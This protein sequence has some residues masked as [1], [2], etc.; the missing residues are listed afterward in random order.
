MEAKLILFFIPHAGSFVRCESG[1]FTKKVWKGKRV[2]EKRL[3]ARWWSSL[4][5]CEKD[6]GGKLIPY[7][8]CNISPSFAPYENLDWN[9][10]VLK[11]N[12]G[13]TEWTSGQRR[14]RNM[15]SAVCLFPSRRAA[16]CLPRTQTHQWRKYRINFRGINIVM[17]IN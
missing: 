2:K 14:E 5:R 1:V 3:T 10:K 12:A 6:A 8:I 9:G 4:C 7:G 17:S 15:S 11:D 16:L 13:T